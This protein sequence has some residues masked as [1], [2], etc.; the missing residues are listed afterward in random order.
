M[1]IDEAI[2]A[3]SD[4]KMKLQR[5]LANPDGSINVDNLS[6]D[7]KCPLGEWMHLLTNDHSAKSFP[8]LELLINEHK[9]F[10]KAAA[11]IVRRKDKGEDIKA[12]ISLGGTSDFA[13]AS[14]NVVSLLMKLKRHVAA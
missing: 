4:W 14:M 10:H 6:Q 1:N 12:D 2:K 5:Y 13:N 9:K 7:N 8:E 3:H 11:D